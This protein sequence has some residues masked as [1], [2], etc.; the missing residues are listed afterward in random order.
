[1]TTI[2]NLAG[3][4]SA[5]ELSIL[6]NEMFPDLTQGVFSALPTD[7]GAASVPEVNA[8]G[9]GLPGANPEVLSPVSSYAPLAQS[10][11]AHSDPVISPEITSIGSVPET[12]TSDIPGAALVPGAGSAQAPV[13][14][15]SYGSVPAADTA[16]DWEHPFAYGGSSTDPYLQTVENA[17]APEAV[18][19]AQGSDV[20]MVSETN[21]AG[22][23]PVVMSQTQ[24][25]EGGKNYRLLYCPRQNSALA[26]ARSGDYFILLCFPRPK[27]TFSADAG[28]DVRRFDVFSPPTP[29]LAA[30]VGGDIGQ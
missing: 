1:M 14:A 16:F 11:E 9:Y 17:A 3:V 20:P 29:V 5:G 10:P 18:F 6:A 23:A 13:S 28:G 4:P 19:S 7:T 8:P 15:G 21:S 24:A 27:L 26:N 25:A 30:D 2:E 22:Y 12:A